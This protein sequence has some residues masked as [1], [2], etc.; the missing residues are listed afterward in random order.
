[1]ASKLPQTYEDLK[2]FILQWTLPPAKGTWLEEQPL[3]QIPSNPSEEAIEAER[4][5]LAKASAQKTA[6]DE[7][8]YLDCFSLQ[9]QEAFPELQEFFDLITAYKTALGNF[10]RQAERNLGCVKKPESQP[11]Y[12]LGCCLPDPIPSPTSAGALGAVAGGRT[13]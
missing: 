7:A 2:Q 5:D 6:V 10:V 3:A 4:S 13:L 12:L 1:M 8:L 9:N 11:G